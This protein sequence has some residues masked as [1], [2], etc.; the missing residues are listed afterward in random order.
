MS[1]PGRDQAPEEFASGGSGRV[2]VDQ[3]LGFATCLYDG[4]SAAHTSSFDDTAVRQQIRTDVLRVETFARGNFLAVSAD[5]FDDG[6]VALVYRKR[7]HSAFS[8]PHI[9]AFAACLAKYR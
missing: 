3:R 7:F 6:R 9:A 8:E 1:L 5:V 2:P 4:F